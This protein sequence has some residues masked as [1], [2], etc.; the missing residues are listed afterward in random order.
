MTIIRGIF[1][2]EFF[3]GFIEMTEII[4]SAFKSNFGDAD[5]FF[6]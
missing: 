4:K 1:S 2:G 5:G 6:G 3:E